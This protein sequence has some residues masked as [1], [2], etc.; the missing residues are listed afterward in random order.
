MCHCESRGSRCHINKADDFSIFLDRLTGG[1]LSV[2]EKT[3]PEF[4][5]NPTVSVRNIETGKM[6]LYRPPTASYLQYEATTPADWKKKAA[7]LKIGGIPNEEPTPIR[8][9][10]PKY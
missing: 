8:R 3:R 10:I 2:Q 4:L 7:T 9:Q 5:H 1:F 6:E